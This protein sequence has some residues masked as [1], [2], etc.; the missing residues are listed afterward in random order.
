MA[1]AQENKTM[2]AVMGQRT[3]T[4]DIFLSAEIPRR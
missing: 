1:A 4:A 3:M 2:S